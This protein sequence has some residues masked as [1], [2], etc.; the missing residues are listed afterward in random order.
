MEKGSGDSVI[1]ATLNGT[2]GLVMRAEKVGIAV[3][4]TG[5]AEALAANQLT[6]DDIDLLIPHQANARIMRAV[7]GHPEAAIEHMKTR[8]NRGAAPL[9][10]LVRTTASLP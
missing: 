5:M 2:G 7:A 4:T 10:T 8:S 1:G 3:Y 9:P 6:V